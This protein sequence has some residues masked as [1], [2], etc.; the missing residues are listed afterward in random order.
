MNDDSAPWQT[1]DEPPLPSEPHHD[2]PTPVDDAVAPEAIE[3]F[4]THV[5]DPEPT[6]VATAPPEPQPHPEPQPQPPP[7]PRQ[8]PRP[9]DAARCHRGLRPPPLDV[10]RYLS[11]PELLRRWLGEVDLELAIG[12]EFA[13]HA[14]NGDVVRG[15]VLQADPPSALAFTWKPHATGA[16]SRVSIRLQGDGPGTRITVRHEGLSSEPERRQARRLWRE[17]LGALRAALHDERDAHQ[18]GASLPI[19][20]RAP[21]SRSAADIWPLLSTAQGLEKWLAHV[22][23]FDGVADGQFRFASRFHGRQVAEEGSIEMLAPENR[24]VL[25]WEW[26]GESWGGRTKVELSL[27]PDP[28]GSAL[29]LLHSGFDKIA[30]EKAAIARREYAVAWPK[31]VGDLRRYVSPLPV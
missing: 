13:L 7:A 4:V 6:P 17:V 10:W 1:P 25:A 16:E 9:P 28:S 15:Q 20:V 3:P 2:E 24:V 26:A 21:L 23:R 11:R 12:G 22:E 31:V 19:A 8:P 30:P 27:E 5:A 14:W 18:W 29:L